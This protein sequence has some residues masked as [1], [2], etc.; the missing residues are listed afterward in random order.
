MPEPLLLRLEHVRISPG[1]LDRRRV[2]VGCEACGEGINYQR[3]IVADRRV[4]C[5]AC[6]GDRYYAY[7]PA[8]DN[9][10]LRHA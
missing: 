8:H 4:L 1:W 5:R 2:R 6:A 7:E 3:E 10:E 9:A